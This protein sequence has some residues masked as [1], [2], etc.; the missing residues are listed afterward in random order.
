[1]STSLN[2]LFALATAVRR[3]IFL[4]A[5]PISYNSIWLN[6]CKR[7]K[8]ISWFQEKKEPGRNFGKYFKQSV[9]QVEC[10]DIYEAVKAKTCRCCDK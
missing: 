6:A 4:K 8:L 7:F 1:M 9:R 10:E 5:S 3:N 2:L